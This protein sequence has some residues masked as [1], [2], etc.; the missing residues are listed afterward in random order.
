ME[1]WKVFKDSRNS[2]THKNLWEVSDQGRIRKNG[3]IIEPGMHKRG[4][5]Y[6]ASV[7][8]HRAVAE[9]FI[10][11]TENKSEVNH[12]NGNKMDFRVANLEWVTHKENMHHAMETGLWDP[13]TNPNRDKKGRY[14]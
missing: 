8:L 4:Y 11:N 7:I 3:K 6:N 13:N 1:N 10:P 14:C 5:A 2:P 9:L 12:I